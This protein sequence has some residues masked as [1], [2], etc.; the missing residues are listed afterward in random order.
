MGFRVGLDQLHALAQGGLRDLDFLEC[1]GHALN[2]IEAG[3]TAFFHASLQ[4][5]DRA[6]YPCDRLGRAFL[7]G[8]KTFGEFVQF[9]GYR[10]QFVW[11]VDC[12]H[13]SGL[14][15]HRFDTVVLTVIQKE[16]VQVL[17]KGNAA[18]LR[19][20]ARDRAGSGVNPLHAPRS[21][22]HFPL[23]IVTDRRLS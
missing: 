21:L 5:E 8:F 7:G 6:V 17:P 3:P 18:S 14:F 16:R 19:F 2:S 22:G 20:L 15:K 12:L 11:L 1:F 9:V 4:I 13:R 23:R 10:L